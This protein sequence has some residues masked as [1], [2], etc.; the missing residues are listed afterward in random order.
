MPEDVT[1]DIYVKGKVSV[2]CMKRN[3]MTEVYNLISTLRCLDA[4]LPLGSSLRTY[5]A[6][7]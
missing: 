1:L 5:I 6:P 3:I 2:S 4:R 7:W